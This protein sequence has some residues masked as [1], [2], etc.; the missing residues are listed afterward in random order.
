[1]NL[2]ERAI[3]AV[4]PGWAAR[5]AQARCRVLAYQTAYEAADPRR[6][7]RKT[8]DFGSGNSAI[9]NSALPLRAYAR[10]LERNH[11]LA[12]GILNTL[13]QN[14]IGPSGIGIEPQPRRTDGTIDTELARVMSSL[15]RDWSRRP[16]VTFQHDWPSAQRL[17][18]RSWFRDGE[19]LLQ[20][21]IGNVPALN[22]GTLVPFSVELIE[23]DLLPLDFDDRARR[24]LQGVERNAWGKPV[25]FHLY[26]THPGDPDANGT[27][28]RK[29]VLADFMRHLKLVDRIGQVRGASMFAAVLSRL[30]DLKDFEESERIAAKVAASMAAFIVKADAQAYETPTTTDGSGVP[31]REITFTPGMVFD[32]L[33]P[34]EKVETIDTKRPNPNA[35]TWRKE[36]L[37]AVASGVQVSYSSA[38]R[39]YNGTYSSQRQELVEQWGAYQ[40]LSHEFITQA[41]RPVYEGF[42]TAAV[43]AG[44]VPTKGVDPLTLYD[45]LYVP[46]AM[47]WIDPLKEATSFQLLED[48]CLVS[49]PELIRR[50]GGTPDDVL[51]SESAWRKRRAEEGLP[52]GNNATN[53][54]FVDEPGN[55]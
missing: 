52:Y 43:L 54:T 11:D 12:R 42:V 20:L 5:R 25:A 22:H 48:L 45:A 50:R 21:L 9:A 1:V 26:K 7:R 31:R 3:A 40:L 28:E 10:Q 44:L 30:D 47:P 27:P 51:Q 32:D 38:A 16:E 33:R 8:K 53:V 36:Q 13:V 39:D 34:G 14:V 46:P 6:L 55:A 2:V 41:A 18:A 4:F 35:A 15:Y 17:L 19:S 49:G 23:A 37:R 24:I 29:R